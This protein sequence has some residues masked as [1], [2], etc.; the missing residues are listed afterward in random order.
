MFANTCGTHNRLY[1]WFV[2]ENLRFID[3]GF[4]IEQFSD[5]I[6]QIL[7]KLLN[8]AILSVFAFSRRTHFI[9]MIGSNGLSQPITNLH[10]FIPVSSILIIESDIL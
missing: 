6:E 10:I 2:D 3:Y 9:K 1:V 8:E 5:K 4:F 7:S